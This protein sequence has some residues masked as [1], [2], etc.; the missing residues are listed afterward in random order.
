MFLLNWYAHRVPDRVYRIGADNAPPYYII[1][2]DGGVHGFAV[3]VL[4]EAARRRGIRLQWVAAPNP[5]DALLDGDVD[6]WPLLAPTP[7][8]L[9]RWHLTEPWLQNHYALMS[10]QSK[11]LATP[12][13]TANARVAVAKS[14]PRAQE[15]AQ[16]FLPH[17]Q[18]LV[19]GD[20]PS[21]LET[22]CAGKADAAFAESRYLAEMLLHRP[23]GCES[24]GFAMH[25]VPGAV[26]KSGIA[27]LPNARAAADSLRVGILE[28]ARDGWL[29]DRLDQWSSVSSSELKSLMLLQHDEERQRWFLWTVLALAIITALLGWQTRLARK[30]RERA[31][32]AN[33]AKSEFLANMSHEIRTPMNG[34]I[35]M[36]ELALDT[37]LTREQR[38]YLIDVRS[39]ANALLRV[40]NDILDFSRIEARKLAIETETFDLR[41]AV[42]DIVRTLSV[43]A[44]KRNIEL[45]CR[46]APNVPEMVV[47][48]CGRLRQVLIN[49]IGNAIKFTERGEVETEV[50]LTS[51]VPGGCR[52]LFSVRDT[53]IGIAKD[54]CARIFEA[55]GQAETATSRKYGGTGLGLTISHRL[56]ELMGGRLDLKS[57]LGKGSRFYF[58]LPLAVS[59][60]QAP[61]PEGLELQQYRGSRVMVVDDNP[62]NRQ[63]LE[64]TLVS[65]KLDVSSAGSGE[66]AVDA[67]QQAEGKG[68]PFRLILMDANMPGMD[69]L[70][71]SERI[72]LMPGGEDVAII[73][74]SSGDFPADRRR[75]DQARFAER[76][77]KPV[78]QSTLRRAIL[79][80]LNHAP[81]TVAPPA[82]TGERAPL[83][84]PRVLLVEDNAVNQKLAR[85]LLEKSGM[86]VETALNGREAVDCWSASDYQIVFM[87]C[88]MPEMDG[89]EATAQIRRLEGA[90]RHTP[91]IAMTAYALPQDRERCL[92]SGMDG[93]VSK[94][95]SEGELRKMLDAFLP[96]HPD[97][98][99]PHAA[100]Q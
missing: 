94:P 76:L 48:D 35:G 18:V 64:E 98:S 42:F 40:I 51:L 58:E 74:L 71:T 92:K 15:L 34:I 13:D 14:P 20:Y 91:I 70:E 79:G 61:G 96:V 77:L 65:W 73:M 80:A 47:G 19:E 75:F 57:E 55:F 28:L 62:T 26:V 33:R 11:E 59:Y 60:H 32:Q 7:E 52:L 22:V 88:Q 84:P 63:I 8:R 72:R 10:L 39:S 16:E 2:A 78:S 30:S 81:A 69:G 1:G 89:F 93:Y 45:L 54:K 67:W 38:E 53:G 86:V 5:A 3:D 21:I 85:R 100:Q 95:I 27:A 90:A 56:V 82:E 31:D 68:T 29:G 37:E 83:E 46:I 23:K 4:N 50:S 87:D 49:L 6:L 43:R 44:A 36:T 12:A 9:K 99:V 41:E 17:A 66:S 24:A 97:G 25:V